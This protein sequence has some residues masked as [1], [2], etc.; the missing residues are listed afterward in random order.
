MVPENMH[1]LKSLINE[2]IVERVDYFQRLLKDFIF[3]MG[4]K[5]R[6]KKE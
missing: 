1:E 5:R 2:V 6:R 4:I 3:E